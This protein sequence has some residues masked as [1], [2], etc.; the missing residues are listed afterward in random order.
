MSAASSMRAS[1]PSSFT[2]RSP[3]T[4]PGSA[5]RVVAPEEIDDIAV[6]RALLRSPTRCRR[7]RGRA[8]DPLQRLGRR[9]PAA[10][11]ARPI[12]L[13]T[14]TPARASSSADWSLVP[15][16]GDEDNVSSAPTRSIAGRAAE[17][18]QVADVDEVR[19]EEGVAGR[20]LHAGTEPP[21]PSRHVHLGEHG[22]VESV[23]HFRTLRVPAHALG[24]AGARPLSRRPARSQEVSRS[25]D[26]QLVAEPSRSRPLSPSATGAMT[27]SPPPRLAGIR[28]RDVQLDDRTGKGGEGVVERPAVVGEG[29]GVHDDCG[30]RARAAC[31][32]AT[33]SA[34]ESLWRCSRS[35]PSRPAC[36]PRPVDVVLERRGAVD[37]RL[38]PAEQLQV[39][40]GEEQQ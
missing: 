37:L 4:R 39:R 12:S 26:R 19:D 25:L 17:A 10:R 18:R 20:L 38:A 16:V 21:E 13:D 11:P 15:A 5:T 24:E 8:V 40:P 32:A 7:P 2:I 31:T 14:S 22:P 33:R 6:A 27:D 28:V 29:T 9:P 35:R 3:S 34:S 30:C 36:C 23:R 1:S